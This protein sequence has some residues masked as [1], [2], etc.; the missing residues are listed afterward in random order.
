MTTE[1]Q[2]V[3][4]YGIL[5]SLDDLADVLKRSRDGLRIALHGN[6]DIAPVFRSP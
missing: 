5:L 6:T 3:D 2:L 4:R 1:E